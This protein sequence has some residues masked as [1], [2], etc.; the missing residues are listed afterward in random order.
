MRLLLHPAAA[1]LATAGMAAAFSN[2]DTA[3]RP[4]RDLPRD[5]KLQI[6][7]VK[8][9]DCERKSRPGDEMSMHY[10]GWLRQNGMV[11]DSSVSRGEPFTFTLGQGTVIQGW[12]NG[13]NDMCVGERRRLTIPSDLG[14]GA[15]G[16]GANIPPGAT[17]V[18]DVE[19]LRIKGPDGHEEL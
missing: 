3:K 16:S 17:I 19:L 8:R 14:Y 18:F 10:T 1:L 5:G 12:E 15:A 9:V 13:L 7:V 11:F 4:G 2:P 6:G